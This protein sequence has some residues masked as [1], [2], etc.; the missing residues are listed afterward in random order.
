[1][2]I[3]KQQDGRYS[4]NGSKDEL[5]ALTLRLSSI[6]TQMDNQD[7][8]N[9]ALLVSRNDPRPLGPSSV[10]FHLDEVDGLEDVQ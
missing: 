7:A 9:A 4:L 6:V 5:K 10:D 8:A 2:K 1:M 3:H